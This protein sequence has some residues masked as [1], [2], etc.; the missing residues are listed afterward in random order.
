MRLWGLAF[1]AMVAVLLVSLVVAAPAPAQESG[2][3]CRATAS[4]VSGAKVCR[5]STRRF[6]AA[7]RRLDRSGLDTA[8][9]SRTY[10]PHARWRCVAYMSSGAIVRGDVVG[11]KVRAWR[12]PR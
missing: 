10:V 1:P 7:A 12:A 2:T 4:G 8:R 5:A 3:A 9:C 6:V 11:R